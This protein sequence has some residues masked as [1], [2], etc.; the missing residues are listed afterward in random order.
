MKDAMLRSHKDRLLEPVAQ[1]LLAGISPNLISF[2]ALVPGLLAAL[3]VVQGH[4]AAGLILWL[5]N[6]LLDGL[7]GLAARVHDKKGDLGGYLDLLLDFLVYLAVPI[8]FVVREPTPAHLWAL[9][10]LLASYQINTLSWTLLS[11]LLE[12]RRAGDAAR[13]TSVEMP[14]GLIEGA[15]T[16]VFYTLFFLLPGHILWLF[17]LMAV[18]VFFTAAQ[19]VWWAWHALQR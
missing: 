3:A 16:M 19:R 13:L 11:A 7:D 17:S 2:L 4:L 15:E 6:R 8:A 12:K 1:S 18:L 9:I 14:A 10:A 5:F